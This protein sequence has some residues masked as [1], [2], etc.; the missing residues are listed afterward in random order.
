MFVVSHICVH[1]LTRFCSNFMSSAL[2]SDMHAPLKK[3][4]F[5]AEVGSY[6]ASRKLVNTAHRSVCRQRCKRHPPQRDELQ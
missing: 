6:A 5:S 3:N 2:R 1:H 4:I